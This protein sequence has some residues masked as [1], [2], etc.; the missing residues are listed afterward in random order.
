MSDET[1][2]GGVD[3]GD[4]AHADALLLELRELAQLLDPVPLEAIA[5]ARSAIAWRTM[6]A[7][8]A[9]LATQTSVDAQSAMVRGNAAPVLLTFDAPELSVEV[10]IL[11]G[12]GGRRLLGQLVP[13]G[14][15]TVHV[16]HRDGSATVAADDVG[17]FSAD[18]LPSGPISLRCEVGGRVV[19]TDWFLP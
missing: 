10:E 3:S 17:R 13:P 4:D 14:A 2:A 9:E 8:L 18:D 12:P 16:R 6:D 11:D 15:G 7:E 5:A 1:N 19:E